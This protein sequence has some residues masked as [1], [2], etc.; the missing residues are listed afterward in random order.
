[1]SRFFDSSSVFKN[2]QNMK[3]NQP[4]NFLNILYNIILFPI[5]KK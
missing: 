1:M 3:F 5:I 4:A 2:E